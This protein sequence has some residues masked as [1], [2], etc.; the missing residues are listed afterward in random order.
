MVLRKGQGFGAQLALA[1]MGAAIGSACGSGPTNAPC[2]TSTACSSG[3]TCVNGTCTGVIE[4]VYPE[5][6]APPPTPLMP[7]DAPLDETPGGDPD[8][9][10]AG[11]D[12]DAGTDA[13]TDTDADTGTGTDADAD[14]DADASTDTDSGR[15]DCPTSD[16]LI[17]SPL[18][19]GSVTLRKMRTPGVPSNGWD[20]VTVGVNESD[21]R[22]FGSSGGPL[23]GEELTGC[24]F[25]PGGGAFFCLTF[26]GGTYGDPN[27]DPLCVHRWQHEVAYARLVP[28]NAWRTGD[29]STLVF[30]FQFEVNESS[31]SSIDYANPACI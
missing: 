13:D 12:T 24:P 4:P 25:A 8:S 27:V 5:D 18:G 29:A 15:T 11:T 9:P 16:G 20:N 31:P 14:A 1:L 10:D 7:R 17:V 3:Q 22:V 21:V 28:T 23:S 26:L 19:M 30:C 2:N 6:G